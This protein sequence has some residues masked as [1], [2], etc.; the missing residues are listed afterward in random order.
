V[1]DF[2]GMMV[3][4][5][6]AS[7]V[8]AAPATI[9]LLKR[10]RRSVIRG[11]MLKGGAEEPAVAA[12]EQSPVSVQMG[13]APASSTSAK[14]TVEHS[15][16]SLALTM[17]V[18]VAATVPFVFVF[19]VVSAI[20][21]EATNANQVMVLLSQFI[22]PLLFA[23]WIVLPKG[24]LRRA[25]VGGWFGVL[26]AL[27]GWAFIRNIDLAIP[28][29][30]SW[31]TASGPPAV[32]IALFMIRPVRAA[33]PLVLMIAGGVMFGVN[34]LYE[35][36]EASRAFFIAFAWF[37]KTVGNNAVIILPDLVGGIVGVLVIAPVLRGLGRLYEHKHTSDQ[38]IAVDTVYLW[39]A[40][41]YGVYAAIE[42]RVWMLSAIV[43]FALYKLVT[44]IG[45]RLLAR[46]ERGRP[47]VDILLLRPFSLGRR[48]ELLFDHLSKVWLRIGAIH[49]IAGPDLVRA[50]VAPSE[51][52]VFLSGRLSRRFIR[53]QAGL[54][55]HL[56]GLD[57]APDPDG[58]HRIN[59]LFCGDNVWRDAMRGLA[60]R[61]RMILMDLRGFSSANQG[62]VFEIEELVRDVPLGRI[63]F[64][65]DGTTDRGFLDYIVEGILERLPDT[66]PNASATGIASSVISVD[67]SAQ[68]RTGL[69]RA[70]MEGA[71]A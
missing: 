6:T 8:L 47:E 41:A 30:Q 43:A 70:I 63:V 2:T 40:A 60:A 58:R 34:S 52:L 20:Q 26:L 46:A 13:T 45:F 15:E 23:V 3:T 50:T 29:T 38:A 16:E 24:R 35:A 69:L 21:M 62:C 4:M 53:D 11:M 54:R 56:E 7:A 10:F 55:A 51:F 33:G 14:P 17:A 59:Q 65:V 49:M 44:F 39:F 36:L 68:S 22:V 37:L 32:L 9:I 64:A 48:S 18:Y 1:D 25:F 67:D 27:V 31:L 57:L 5:G 19:G 66:S 28:M 42:G 12:G 61:S 71:A